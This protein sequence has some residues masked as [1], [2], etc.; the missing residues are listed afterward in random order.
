MNIIKILNNMFIKNMFLSFRSSILGRLRLESVLRTCRV[1]RL[2]KFA[3]Y[4]LCIFSLPVCLNMYAD[5]V[6]QKRKI[7]I[8]D[9][10][11]TSEM[12]SLRTILML[13]ECASKEYSIR[14]IKASG[15]IRGEWMKDAAL[16]VIPGG[17]D[18]PYARKLNGKGNDNIK[19]F[20]SNGGSFLG[21]CAGAYYGSGSIEFDKDGPLEIVQDRELAFF[22]GTA[23]GPLVQYDYDN[24]SGIKPMKLTYIIDGKPIT[25]IFHYHGG[26]Y[27]KDADTYNSVKVLGRLD[28]HDNQA[29]VISILYGKGKV[30]LSGI[31]FEYNPEVDDMGDQHVDSVRSILSK[32]K[33]ERYMIFR[34]MIRKLGLKN[35]ESTLPGVLP[36]K[37]LHL[38]VADNNRVKNRKALNGKY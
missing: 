37:I 11:G 18:L 20:V 30:I 17:A 7:Y 12:Y 14:R 10:E 32:Y 4:M 27:F 34:D 38:N 9:D 28:D 16:L 25:G 22:P 24:L 13:K 1:D 36:G 5:P 15:I 3:K 8:Y 6:F 2:Y 31:H 35:N 21:I 29:A 23:A 33:K 19:S 26:S